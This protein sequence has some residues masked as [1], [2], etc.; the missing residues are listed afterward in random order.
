M[1]ETPSA[2]STLLPATLVDLAARR[3]GA[4]AEERQRELERDLAQLS[5][6]FAA[7]GTP[8]SA[9]HRIEAALRCQSDVDERTALAWQML[10]EVAVAARIEPVD[11]LTAAMKEALDEI[12]EPSLDLIRRSFPTDGMPDSR[13]RLAHSVNRARQRAYAEVDLFVLE[14][15]RQAHQGLR[16]RRE[17]PNQVAEMAGGR[18]FLSHAAVDRGLAQHLRDALVAGA[19]GVSV[20]M[21]SHPGAI[22]TGRPWFEDVLH[23]LEG[24]AYLVLLTRASCAS[25]WVAFETGVAWRSG[26]P[27][28][29]LCAGGLEPNAVASPFAGFQLLTLDARGGEGLIQAFRSLRLAPPDDVQ[30]F[31]ERATELA[32]ESEPLPEAQERAGQ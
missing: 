32:R 25:L 2:S 28:V 14:A 16:K 30:T 7:N 9:R 13:E 31:I 29:L 27:S 11:G 22:G 5:A 18:I 26:R 24:A 21:A 17:P 19:P 8:S 20:F 23:E 10:R 3:F 15:D 4:R 6:R 1:S 12:V